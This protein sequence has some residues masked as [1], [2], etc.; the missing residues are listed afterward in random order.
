MNKNKILSLVAI[1]FG[2]KTGAE[3]PAQLNEDQRKKLED[4]YGKKAAAAYEEFI[5]PDASTEAVADMRTALEEHFAELA[6][7]SLTELQAQ[8]NTANADLEKQRKLVAV[9]SASPEDDLIPEANTDSN[10]TSTAPKVLKVNMN[11]AIYKDHQAH[12]RNGG[13]MADQGKTI[14]HNDLTQE[15]GTYL[16]QGNNNREIITQIF[17]GFTSARHFVV[18]PAV[19]EYQASQ[20]EINSVVQQFTNAWTPKGNTKFTP[21]VIKNRRHKINVPIIPSEVGISYLFALYNEGMSPDQ[22]PITKWITQNLIIPQVLDDIELRMIAK[23]KFVATTDPTKPT[24]PEEGMDGLETILV[25]EKSNAN[26]KVK[27]ISGFDTF[28][29]DTATPEQVLKFVNAMVT[30]VNPL[31]KNKKKKIYMS[32]DNIRIYQTAYKTVWAT[33]AG[34][35]GDFG[36]LKVDYSIDTLVG[37]DCLIGSPIV[38][39]TTENNMVRLQHINTPPKI[40]NDVQKHDY[41][42]RL[43]GEFWLAIGFKIAEAITAWVPAGYNPTAKLIELF[44]AS[45]KFGDGTEPAQSEIV[46]PANN[47]GSNPA[48]PAGSAGGGV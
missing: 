36:D 34:I 19:D 20:A 1:L 31:Y 15:F 38:F 35:A 23:G 18:V 27:F 10:Y 45:N 32:N 14:D 46:S 16:S 28:N 43:Y 4:E 22:M 25:N 40:I 26:T 11:S 44:G 9:L 8:L 7:Q 21:L 41:E 33:G 39:S 6:G 30:Q 5:K 29:W 12:V 47:F 24:N 37:L 48:A 2:F 13:L 42:V 3:A 17:N